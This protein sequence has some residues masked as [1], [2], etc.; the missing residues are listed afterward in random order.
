MIYKKKKKDVAITTAYR[1]NVNIKNTNKN[2]KKRL[3]K[4]F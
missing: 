2:N 4:R 1:L 3:K